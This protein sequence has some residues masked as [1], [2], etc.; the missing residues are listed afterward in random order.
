MAISKAA[1]A[2]SR[3][4]GPLQPKGMQVAGGA[5]VLLLDILRELG[6]RPK[7]I[8]PTTE[9]DLPPGEYLRRQEESS[10]RLS[11]AGQKRFADA[12]YDA[13][14]AIRPDETV[15]Q[16]EKALTESE[17]SLERLMGDADSSLRSVDSETM[18]PGTSQVTGYVSEAD[19]ASV[20]AAVVDETIV[21][22]TDGLDF[23]F[24]KLES[25]EDVTRLINQVS[26][27]FADP[28]EAQRRG[29]Q[30]NIR[31]AAMADEMLRDELGLTRKLFQRSQGEL[32][33]AEEMLAVRRLLIRSGD[34]L[35]EMAKSIDEGNNSTAELIQFRRQLAIHGGIQA[36]AKGAQTEIARALQSFNIP[37]SARTPAQTQQMLQAILDESGGQG[38]TQ[39]I[40]TQI[41]NS[42][43]AGGRPGVND[44]VRN[45]WWSARNIEGVLAEVYVNG[46]LSSPVTHLKNFV[47]TP[48]FMAYNLPVE[49]LA[50]AIGTVER[51]VLRTAGRDTGVF[52]G[53]ATARFFGLTQSMRDAWRVAAITFRTEKPSDF[54]NKVENAQYRA[55]DAEQLG[56]SGNTG[57]FVDFLGKVIRLP[58]RGLMAA[59]DFWRVV[60]QRGELYSRSYREA[61][62]ALGQ[63]KS[64][65]EAF[66]NFLM[67][68]H[69]SRSVSGELDETARYY[70]LTSD[71]G[72]FGK[73]ARSVRR[74][75]YIGWFV[76]PFVGAPTNAILRTIEQYTGF[77]ATNWSQ[78]LRDPAKRQK[79]LARVSMAWGA[80]YTLYNYALEGRLTGSFPRNP[81]DR[82]RLPPGWQ[83]YS[84]VRRGDDWPTDADGDPLPLYNPQTGAPNGRLTYISYGGLEPVG[85]LLAIAAE[86]AERVRQEIEP[87]GRSDI[88][89]KG[90]AAA[91]KH[92]SDLPMLQAVGD[93]VTAFETEDWNYIL[94]SPVRGAL[95]YSA[96]VRTVERA[97][98]PRRVKPGGRIEY[99]TEE[100]VRQMEPDP[101][102]RGAKLDLIGM[103]KGTGFAPFRNEMRRYYGMFTDRPLS[104]DYDP[105]I[106]G[107][108]YDV[109]GR[110]KMM[111]VAFSENPLLATWNSI[112]PFKISPGEALSPLQQEIVNSG[113]PLREFKDS[114]NGMKFPDKAFQS[115]W[116]NYAKNELRIVYGGEVR[117]FVEALEWL[118]NQRSYYRA[119]SHMV[120][121]SPEHNQHKHTLMRNLEDTF[122]EEGLLDLLRLPE[123]AELQQAYD[124]I[125]QRRD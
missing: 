77:G 26:D 39:K 103:P 62:V 85:A 122:F 120:Q 80:T 43:K 118:V 31:T 75:P 34:R 109:L 61:A 74:T 70:T 28:I 36:H 72:E 86:T 91:S 60:V 100:E 29:E 121:D 7:V 49:L 13:Q 55:I 94:R 83:P 95:P 113:Y 52:I 38:V 106:T 48:L 21:S 1:A 23:N 78:A 22:G 4:G 76:A 115:R 32:L 64:N 63:G 27:I 16:A 82:K 98:D 116:V 79:A 69:D 9:R 47:G 65:E 12:G 105:Q 125:Q 107:I 6:A 20:R 81:E 73:I 2:A 71:A 40:A 57:R 18:Q 84:F 90:V 59:D 30:M 50:G 88:I 58:G 5:R 66:D 11:E 114:H 123:N 37:A 68:L 67:Q 24:D 46:L 93:I 19:A 14:R 33:N 108:Q 41:L 110:E 42:H 51:S 97:V 119:P 10:Q 92:F 117:G 54:R 56:L 87:Q 44:V 111:N 104:G 35:V 45:R 102:T 124:S 15:V 99:Y 17:E 89:I 25:G 96:L 8:V 112:L 53:E 3:T 101:Y